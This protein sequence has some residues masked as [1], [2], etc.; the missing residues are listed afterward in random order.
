MRS[1]Y[2]K[3]LRQNMSWSE[4]VGGSRR[5]TWET[6]SWWSEQAV[7]QVLDQAGLKYN[8]VKTSS[9]VNHKWQ[10]IRHYIRVYI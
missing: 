4:W 3:A 1:E 5:M 6:R 7:Q 2:S 8:K 10:N 9:V